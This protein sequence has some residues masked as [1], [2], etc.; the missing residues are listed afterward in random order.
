MNTMVGTDGSMLVHHD[1]DAE[2]RDRE[3]RENFREWERQEQRRRDEEQRVRSDS[4]Y[5][6]RDWRRY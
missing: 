3:A 5:Q 4:I 6:L 1:P 2:E